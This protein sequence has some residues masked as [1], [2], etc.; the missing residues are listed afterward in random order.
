[1]AK[2]NLAPEP[3]NVIPTDDQAAKLMQ[4]SEEDEGY[5]SGTTATDD[6]GHPYGDGS[7]SEGSRKSLD[8]LRK[9][10]AYGAAGGSK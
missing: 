6:A 5:S 8:R 3:D 2:N 7:Y 1:M 10:A 9:G 4:Q